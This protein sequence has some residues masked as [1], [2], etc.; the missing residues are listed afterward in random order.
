MEG[1]K[2]IFAKEI[3]D[4]GGKPVLADFGTLTRVVYIVLCNCKTVGLSGLFLVVL[5]CSRVTT[6]MNLLTQQTGSSKK[7]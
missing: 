7:R 3:D 4:R 2:R 1:R 5:V 6:Q